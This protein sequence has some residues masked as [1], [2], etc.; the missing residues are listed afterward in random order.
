[1]GLK[2]WN[3]TQWVSASPSIQVT[4]DIVTNSSQVSGQTLTSALNDLNNRVPSN[5][6]NGYYLKKT[7]QGNTWAEVQGGEDNIYIAEVEM[8]IF[9]EPYTITGPTFAT[10][11]AAYDNNKIIY[12]KAT[13]EI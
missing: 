4:T 7:A 1:M 9:T 10:V 8:D 11:K 2:K 12:A 6:T 13:A 5:G 3:G